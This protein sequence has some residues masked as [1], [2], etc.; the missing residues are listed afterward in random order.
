LEEILTLEEL[1]LLY[2]ACNNEFTKSIK[3]S[4]MAAG[5]EVSF[6]EDDW[7]DPEPPKKPEAIAGN[8]LRF[9]PIGLGYEG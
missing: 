1:F 7:F 6:D 5:A 2:R 4:A 9:L 3:I 8:D